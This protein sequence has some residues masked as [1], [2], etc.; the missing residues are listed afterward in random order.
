MRWLVAALGVIGL[1]CG[2]YF[3][4]E[5]RL[6]R[7][8]LRVA[9]NLRDNHPD[10][11]GL[12]A[13]VDLALDARDFRVG[14]YRLSTAHQRVQ[15]NGVLS[16]P[17][18]CAHTLLPG[19]APDLV[20][21]LE[22]GDPPLILPLP[23]QEAEAVEAWA[24]D[25]GWT[26]VVLSFGREAGDFLQHSKGLQAITL[27]P[28]GTRDELVAKVLGLRPDLI[29]V[30]DLLSWLWLP[31]DLHARIRR[32]GFAGQL[33]LRAALLALDPPRSF[34]GYR[35]VLASM[36]H[37]P[38]DF[39]RRF[40]GHSSPFV[41]AGYRATERYLRFVELNP[42]AHPVELARELMNSSIF[43]ELRGA[44]AIYEVKEG[45]FVPVPPK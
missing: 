8:V 37:A 24:K 38:P 13:G 43:H 29:F 19:L 32:G 12:A 15:P 5:P 1:A 44:P 3:G 34:E 26:C 27:R 23:A 2:V 35:A 42:D 21:S 22:A 28:T 41:Y 39:L 14:P 31:D 17:A 33:F 10:D 36:R 30:D 25:R 11:A 6:R 4:L 18:P 40:P 9:L 20:L 16:I 7:P 45:R